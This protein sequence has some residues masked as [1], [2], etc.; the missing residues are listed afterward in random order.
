MK[1]RYRN[2]KTGEE[3]T[4]RNRVS[5]K[6]WELMEDHPV[7]PPV[8]PPAA[9]PVDPPTAPPKEKSAKKGKQ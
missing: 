1:Y 6:N 3:V 8:A 9:P 7:A 5:G 4:T 2:R